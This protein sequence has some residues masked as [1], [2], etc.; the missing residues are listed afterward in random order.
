MNSRSKKQRVL[1]VGLDYSGPTLRNTIIETKG[2]CRPDIAPDQ[3]ATPLYNYDAIIIYPAS[4]SHF[5]FGRRGRYSDSEKELWELKRDNNEHDLDA[6]F[7]RAER[8]EE[9]KAALEQGTRVVFV[10]APEKKIHFFGWRSL[11]LAYLNS[12]VE[13]LAA[14]TK[15]TSKKSSKLT[16][17]RPAHPF[18]D[19]FKQLTLDGWILCALLP[20]GRDYVVLAS[21]PENKALGIEMEVEGART[22]LI[23]PPSSTRALRSLIAV[24]LQTPSLRE[25]RRYHGVFLSHTHGDKKF[26]NRLKSALNKHGVDDVWVDEAEIMVGDS[27]QSK[28]E[29]AITKTRY[30]GVILSPRSVK[31]RW[32]RKE[33]EIA[34]QKELE[35]DSV[36]VLP[37]LFEKCEIPAFLKPK[38]YADFTSPDTFAKSVEK[39]LRRLALTDT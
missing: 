2:L 33:L 21:T 7:D 1:L 18:A 27:L 8:S 19:Y 24:T 15:F 36:V 16:I 38:V 22:W 26:V 32:V 34:M 28:I 30:F 39:L 31:S 35:T 4:Y 37:L 14:E 17:D 6:A 9:L 3:A 29:D 5:L 11:Y 13:T 25:Q 20:E 10:M 12:G 23:S